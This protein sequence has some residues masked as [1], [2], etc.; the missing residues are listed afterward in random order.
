M[1]QEAAQ[2]GR[3]PTGSG[4]DVWRSKGAEPQA[5]TQRPPPRQA[6]KVQA[7][8]RSRRAQQAGVHSGA[9]TA[10]SHTQQAP[11]PLPAARA[12]SARPSLR[13]PPTPPRPATSRRSETS[14]LGVRGSQRCVIRPCDWQRELGRWPVQHLAQILL[15]PFTRRTSRSRSNAPL[16][17]SRDSRRRWHR[18][19]P[20]DPGDPPTSTACPGL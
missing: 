17:E 9:R 7:R 10:G 19:R 6:G 15:K 16:G 14:A 18:V 5:C 8:V 20:G 2:G 1:P 4:G 3:T 11:H 13:P 12:R